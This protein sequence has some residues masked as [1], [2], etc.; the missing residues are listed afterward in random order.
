MQVLAGDPS[1]RGVIQALQFGL[2]GVQGGRITLDNMTWPMTLGADA[3]EKVNAGQPA[4]LFLAR[5]GPGPRLDGKRAAK[6]SQHP[7]RARLFGA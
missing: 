6:V 4:T 7:G 2:L 1:L 3:I 5:H